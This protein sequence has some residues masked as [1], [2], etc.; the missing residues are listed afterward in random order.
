[1]ARVNGRVG[2]RRITRVNATMDGSVYSPP[3]LVEQHIARDLEHLRARLRPLKVARRHVAALAR[4]YP[5]YSFEA[6]RMERGLYA[7]V[8]NGKVKPYVD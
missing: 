8:C 3:P 4:K 1:M 5:G 6:I 2:I 7:I